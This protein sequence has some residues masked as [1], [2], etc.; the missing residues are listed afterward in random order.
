MP[1][2][3]QGR[4]RNHFPLLFD[5]V[6]LCSCEELTHRHFQTVTGSKAIKH[7]RPK[8]AALW[9]SS[10][11]PMALHSFLACN[12]LSPLLPVSAYRT[13]SGEGPHHSR[14][15]TGVTRA[16]SWGVVPD[17]RQ[18]SGAQICA[19]LGRPGELQCKA[20]LSASQSEGGADSHCLI[21]LSY[22]SSM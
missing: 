9:T 12:H 8:C 13:C 1:P 11:P 5:V 18:G 2:L 6:I 4:W 3:L 22:C 14:V 19:S 17:W 21:L 7:K 16:K 20:M 15:G 10:N